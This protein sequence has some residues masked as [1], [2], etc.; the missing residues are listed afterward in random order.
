MSA[1][2]IPC[3]DVPKIHGNS[4][5]KLNE[6][7][8]ESPALTEFLDAF[9]SDFESQ[10]DFETEGISIKNFSEEKL[11]RS[12]KM[13]IAENKREKTMHQNMQEYKVR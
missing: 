2:Y 13:H 9:G 10:D 4:L 3:A 12:P 11:K 7:E 5:F 8:S 1:F 6:K